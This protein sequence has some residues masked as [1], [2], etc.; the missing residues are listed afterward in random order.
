MTY[1]VEIRSKINHHRFLQ[2]DAF[3]DKALAERWGQNVISHCSELYWHLVTDE[4]NIVE[5]VLREEHDEH[6][7]EMLE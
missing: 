5:Q 3:E 2:S 7:K 4:N 6:Q 1:W